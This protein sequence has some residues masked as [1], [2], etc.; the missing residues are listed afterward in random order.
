MFRCPLHGAA[1]AVIAALHQ[2]PLQGVFMAIVQP[3]ECAAKPLVRA[4]KIDDQSRVGP[5]K[6][7]VECDGWQQYV[8]SSIYRLGSI[9]KPGLCHG[10]SRIELPADHRKAQRDTNA[11]R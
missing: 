5:T 3:N 8:A 7:H 2:P 10:L 1:S 4:H 11:G 6:L 9:R